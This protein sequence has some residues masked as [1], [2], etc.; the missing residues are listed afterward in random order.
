[1]ARAAV[2]E[3]RKVGVFIP[4]PV[5]RSGCACRGLWC[6]E[7]S[8]PTSGDRCSGKGGKKRGLLEGGEWEGWAEPTR[9]MEGGG[10][11][12]PRARCRWWS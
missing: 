8:G 5:G 4:D 11:G 1:M 10:G 9:G 2:G 6:A 3:K 12:G 7:A